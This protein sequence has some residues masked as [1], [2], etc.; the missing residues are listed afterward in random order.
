MWKLVCAGVL[1]SCLYYHACINP[2]LR[3]HGSCITHSLIL[4]YTLI[5][6]VLRAEESY[7]AH[8]DILY[9]EW[10]NAIL[11][12]RNFYIVHAGILYYARRTCIS[13]MQT[14]LM[15]THYYILWIVALTVYE[16]I[17]SFVWLQKKFFL[18]LC[19]FHHH[20]AGDW[21]IVPLSEKQEGRRFVMM[22]DSEWLKT[23]YSMRRLFFILLA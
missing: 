10:G 23:K 9:Y 17:Y 14:I 2:I 20:F 15:I 21:F 12:T 7:I 16:E 11:C 1:R 8:L 3:A 6:P 19:L 5:N 13:W 18:S 4:Y 22:P